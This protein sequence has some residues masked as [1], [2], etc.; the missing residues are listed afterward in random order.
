MMKKPDAQMQGGAR[1]DDPGSGTV[2]TTRV[3][4]APGIQRGT[5]NEMAAA[6]SS[7]FAARLQEISVDEGL[8]ADHADAA[9]SGC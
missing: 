6:A 2:L 3:Q 5:P 4:Q 9:V 1:D 7:D 8:A